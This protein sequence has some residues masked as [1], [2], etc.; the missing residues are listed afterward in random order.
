MSGYNRQPEIVDKLFQLSQVVTV[1]AAMWPNPI[2]INV[3]FLS[4]PYITR[5]ESFLDFF[6]ALKV[7]SLL[8]MI[9]PPVWTN[10]WLDLLTFD[11]T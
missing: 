9:F 11:L 2:F 5:L 7:F 10:L 6:S 1:G 8:P 4:F 3:C